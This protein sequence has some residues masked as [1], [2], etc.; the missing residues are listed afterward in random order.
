M[1]KKD[2]LNF[3][4]KEHT[5]ESATNI[6]MKRKDGKQ[7]TSI[8]QISIDTTERSFVY[9]DL[10]NQTTTKILWTKEEMDLPSL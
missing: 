10:L 2:L 8:S 9:N 7:T 3:H 6:L 5:A 1:A 4:Q